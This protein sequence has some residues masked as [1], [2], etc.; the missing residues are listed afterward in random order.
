MHHYNHTAHAFTTKTTPIAIHP[1]Q[2]VRLS[3]CGSAVI[4]EKNARNRL[5][6]VKAILAMV[7]SHSPLQ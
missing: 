5:M 6:M 7:I 1:I 2:V 4:M 3:L